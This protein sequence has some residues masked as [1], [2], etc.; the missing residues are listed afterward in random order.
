MKNQF[1]LDVVAAF[2]WIH[3]SASF[4]MTSDTIL[5]IMRKENFGIF[6]YIDDFIMISPENDAHSQF[7]KLFD[8]LS[9]LG[10]PMNQ[11][12]LTS[13]CRVL[14]CLG[15]T[16]NLD[17]NSLSIDKAKMDEMYS[18]CISVMKKRTLSRR[19]LQSL[20]GKLLYLH[21]CIKPARIFVNRILAV[22]ED[23][24]H[25][26]RIKLTKE[27]HKD[28]EWFINFL[29]LFS[30]STSIFKLDIH[31]PHTLHID[32]CLTGVGVAG[33]IGYTKPLPLLL[34]I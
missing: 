6:A 12:K 1:F 13:P 31:N 10:L 5:Y 19:Q 34:C 15:I 4:Q 29:P 22:F 20:L 2:G 9:Y 18:E 24:P 26:K 28:V 32:P 33:M 27:F 23:N 8:F 16:I 7:K 3:G 17:N 30:G 14:T 11:D 21:K 25:K